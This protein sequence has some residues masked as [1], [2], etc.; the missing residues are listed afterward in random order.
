MGPKKR[1]DSATS[2]RAKETA[3]KPTSDGGNASL[4]PTCFRKTAPITTMA[5]V[6]LLRQGL[7]QNGISYQQKGGK[8]E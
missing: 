6:E 2:K 7:T 8:K 5:C 1:D 4:G 3:F